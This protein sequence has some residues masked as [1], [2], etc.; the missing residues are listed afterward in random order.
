MSEQF[1]YAEFRLFAKRGVVTVGVSRAQE[2]MLEVPRKLIE[3]WKR[4]NPERELTDQA[5][6]ADI[7]L[8]VV[9]DAISSFPDLATYEVDVPTWL[10]ERHP[11]M[12]ARAC[13]HHDNGIRAW[14]ITSSDDSQAIKVLEEAKQE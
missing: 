8:V 11:I 14:V 9:Q 3:D 7:A 1:Y 13:D 2:V 6:A 12:N 5:I 4:E 10:E